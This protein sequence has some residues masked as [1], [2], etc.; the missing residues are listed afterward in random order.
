MQ[1]FT[2]DTRR[3]GNWNTG[4]EWWFYADL[5]DEMRYDIIEFLKTF[6]DVNYPGDYRFE[7]P[8]YAPETVQMRRGFPSANQYEDR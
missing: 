2:Y 1:P 7:R 3:I 6:D 8:A 5:D 4:H